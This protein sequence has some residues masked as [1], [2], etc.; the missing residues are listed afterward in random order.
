MTTARSSL[1]HRA[2]PRAVPARWR[3][4]VERILITDDKIALRLRSLSRQIQRDFTGCELVIVSLLNGTV[5]F[6]ADLIR[7]VSL[8]LRLDFIGV[9]SYGAGTE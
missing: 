4:E 6:L 2:A 8:P 5:M 3:K 7:H 1:R 9:S